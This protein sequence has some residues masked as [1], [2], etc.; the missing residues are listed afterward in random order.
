MAYE[1][2]VIFE[3]TYIAILFY[4]WQKSY[5]FLGNKQQATFDR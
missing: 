5:C 3:M 2:K 1:L 4:S